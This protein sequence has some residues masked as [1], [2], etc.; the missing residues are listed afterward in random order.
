MK[1]NDVPLFNRRTFK[2]VNSQLLNT[3]STNTGL[4]TQFIKRLVIIRRAQELILQMMIMFTVTRYAYNADSNLVVK[5]TTTITNITP[6]LSFR[7]IR[8]LI[9]LLDQGIL[10]YGRFTI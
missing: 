1:N 2:F 6:R 9:F 7:P 3:V 4:L 5:Y 10:S 8:V